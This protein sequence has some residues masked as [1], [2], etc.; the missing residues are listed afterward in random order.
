MSV[1]KDYVDKALRNAQEAKELLLQTFSG[2]SGDLEWYLHQF[3]EALDCLD[4][5][6]DVR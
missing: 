5:V 4:S 3:D 6:R 2:D 1:Y